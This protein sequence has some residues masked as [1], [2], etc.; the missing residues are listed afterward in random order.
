MQEKLENNGIQ[1]NGTLRAPARKSAQ[2]GK[3]KAQA[4]SA[5]GLF[6]VA[7]TW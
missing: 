5:I 6:A 7:L 2:S 3:M 1:N 4:K